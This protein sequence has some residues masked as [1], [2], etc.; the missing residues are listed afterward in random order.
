METPSLTRIYAYVPQNELTTV[1]QSIDSLGIP[2]GPAYDHI[3]KLEVAGLLEK[4]RDQRLYEHD[5]E[6][7]SLILSTNGGSDDHTRSYRRC[8][9]S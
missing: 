1:S 7:I 8:G 2:Q 5:A 3:Q 6:S 4:T 9:P